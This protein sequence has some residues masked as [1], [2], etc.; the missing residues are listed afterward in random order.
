MSDNRIVNT[1]IPV[2]SG[3]FLMWFSKLDWSTLS[4]MTGITVAVL[5]L[6]FSVYFQ[7]RKDRRD[8]HIHKATIEALKKGITIDDKD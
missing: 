6:L 8:E 4:F 1:I 7:W 5:G 3:G 2:G